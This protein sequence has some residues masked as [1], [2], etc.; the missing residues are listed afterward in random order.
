MKEIK[1][2]IDSIYDEI[3]GAKEYAEKYVI[4]KNMD[5]STARKYREMA[6]Q[7]IAHAKTLQ[8]ITASFAEKVSWLPEC[9]KEELDKVY[10][11]RAEC[12]AVVKLMLAS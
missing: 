1:K 10:A 8:E 11:K 3:E 5:L 2:P 9:D 12:E 7:E 6:E 4:L